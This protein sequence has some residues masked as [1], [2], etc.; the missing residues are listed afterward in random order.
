MPY[1]SERANDGLEIDFIARLF[2]RIPKREIIEL[3]RKNY[4]VICRGLFLNEKSQK[5]NSSTAA[6]T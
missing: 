1:S 2:T 3:A 6:S 5:L 4:F